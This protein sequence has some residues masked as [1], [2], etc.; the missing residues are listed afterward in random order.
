MNTRM[1]VLSVSLVLSTGTTW[2]GHAFGTV[3]CGDQVQAPKYQVGEKWSWQ[4][5]KGQE[6]TDTVLRWKGTSP[7]FGG[8]TVR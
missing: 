7:K 2:G 5:E 6:L 3:E 1:L 4:D 8:A